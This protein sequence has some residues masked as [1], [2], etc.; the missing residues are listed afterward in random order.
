LIA[1]GVIVRKW[2]PGERDPS[3]YA[4][5]YDTDKHKKRERKTVRVVKK[6]QKQAQQLL[7]LYKLKN[8]QI[9]AQGQRAQEQLRHLKQQHQQ[10]PVA[11]QP[12]TTLDKQL[13]S[14][15]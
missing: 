1:D 8:N 13:D 5:L 14:L 3:Y 10:S 2:K 15:D 12:S 9:L 7:Q 6:A 4:K 11:S